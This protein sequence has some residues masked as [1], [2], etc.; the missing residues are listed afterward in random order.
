MQ[1]LDGFIQKSTNEPSQDLARFL[2][3]ALFH[4]G[5]L[6]LK[7]Y[8]V[9]PEPGTNGLPAPDPALLSAAITNL[10]RLIREFADSELLGS[11][12][13]DRGWCDLARGDYAAATTNFSAAGHPPALVGEPSRSPF[14]TGRRLL[15]AR[16]LP[17]G[18]GSL[19]PPT[20]GLR[21]RC[22]A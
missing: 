19:Q 6:K 10:D 7:A 14:E 18:E 20:P 21:P 3:L 5:D 2:D 4:L 15:P 8:F 12:F 17:G 16:R 9:P 11:A 22:R 13:L 1:W